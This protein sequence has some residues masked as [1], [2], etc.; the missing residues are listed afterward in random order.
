MILCDKEASYYPPVFWVFDL[1][2]KAYGVDVWHDARYMA[3]VGSSTSDD[4]QISQAFYTKLLQ[5]KI[6]DYTDHFKEKPI[7]RLQN[8]NPDYVSTIFYLVNGFQEYQLPSHKAD[9]YGRLDF[10]H[11][12]QC[13]FDIVKEDLVKHYV[14]RLLAQVDPGLKIPKRKS[15]IFLSHDI[16]SIYGSL[17]Y[18]GIW[19]LKHLRWRDFFKVILQIIGQNPPWF[20]IDKIAKLENAHDVR[21]CYYWIV[22][23][24]R[25]RQGIKNGDYDFAD[26]RVQQQYRIAKDLGNEMGLHKS[27]LPTSFETEI[28]RMDTVG[29]NRHHFLRIDNPASF[30]QMEAAGIT[31]DSSI[32]FPYHMGF[33][34]SFG[35]PFFPFDLEKKKSTNVLEIPLHIMDGMFAIKDKQSEN[36]AFKE[37]TDFIEANKENAIISILW[38]NSEMTEFAYRWSFSCYKRLLLY[39]A[40]EKFTAVLPNQILK[41]YIAR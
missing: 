14:E 21:A 27:T 18:D 22:K 24:G 8:G 13:Q 9:K 35:M 5:N 32:G 26:R 36:Q 33:K 3:K 37:I 4:I 25:D 7:I 12:L 15:R 28:Q 23:N 2:N 16:D 17:K 38:H 39:F 40:E 20:N 6:Y 31:S 30:R 19:A 29:P 34:N 10:P 1:I 11:S 41:E